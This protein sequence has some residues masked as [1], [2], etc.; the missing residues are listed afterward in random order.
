MPLVELEDK[1]LARLRGIERDY[2]DAA[3]WRK[4]ASELAADPLTKQDFWTIFKKK[5]PDIPTEH[6]TAM[7]YA[8]PLR[9]EL[10]AL[11][12]QIAEDKEA[13]EKAE[14]ERAE[15][16]KKR[17]VS[18]TIDRAKVKL[19]ANGWDE[20]GVNQIVQLMIDRNIPDFDVAEAYVRSQMPT[21]VTLD[22]AYEG[23]D[24]DWFSPGDDQPDAKLLMD[25]PRKYKTDMVRRFM[26]D[27]ANG[28]LQAWAA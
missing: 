10:D 6:D 26:Q 11:K 22:R 27:K 8:K 2:A 25:N 19:R 16:D 4:V 13:R 12:K 17:N 24:L 21:P 20:D 9:D 3:N 15:N 7:A 18:D 5:H 23:R 14:A 1:E 28:N